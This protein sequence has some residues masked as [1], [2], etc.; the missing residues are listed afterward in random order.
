MEPAFLPIA[1]AFADDPKVSLGR[2]F[3]S[4]SLRIAH[5]FM[6]LESLAFN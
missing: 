6:P 2:R 5:H 4:N 3:G 1:A